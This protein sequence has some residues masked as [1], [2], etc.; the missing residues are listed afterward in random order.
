MNLTKNMSHEITVS[1]ISKPYYE[2][3]IKLHKTLKYTKRTIHIPL[4]TFHLKGILF[5]VELFIVKMESHY[6]IIYIQSSHRNEWSITWSAQADILNI[7]LNI[8]GNQ[9]K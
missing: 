6:H 8:C 3:D 5:E 2:L 7:Y 1:Y 4:F 9:T